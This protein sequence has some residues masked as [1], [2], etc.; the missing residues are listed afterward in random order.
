MEISYH[1][2]KSKITF[3]A[4]PNE[5]DFEFYSARKGKLC[6]QTATFEMPDNFDAGKTHPDILGLVAILV[7][8]P[9]SHREIRLA[10]K[11]S[12]QLAQASEKFFR[13][14]LE[15]VDFNLSKRQAS[16]K[17]RPSL[18]FSG[19]VDSFAALKLMPD[20]TMPVFCH[21]IVPEGMHQGLYRADAALLACRDVS[22]SHNAISI[23]TDMEYV[24][25]P[26]GFGVDW[27]NAAGAVL[28]ADHFNFNS[29][30][31]GMVME[32]AY[33]IGHPHYSNLRSRSVYRAWSPLFEA[34]GVP[35]ALPTAGLSEVVTSKIALSMRDVWHPD[36]C[37][38][39][40]A[41][42]PC[43]KCFKCFRKKILDAKLEGSEIPKNHFEIPYS[44]KEV[45]RRLLEQP[46][47]H[48]D[49]LAYSLQ[50]LKCASNSVLHALLLKCRSITDYGRGLS[51]LD[52]HYEKSFELVPEFMRDELAE[53]IRRYAEPYSVHDV[54]LIESWETGRLLEMG[55][56]QKGQKW[57]ADIL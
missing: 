53:K 7:F 13:R 25:D 51:V 21:R 6:R 1:I 43:M 19:G 8:G 50:D 12:E 38:R 41:G 46:I 40:G 23:K 42:Q 48:E 44:S 11:I 29:V 36:S 27:T 56:Y 2:Q 35:I 47:H 52:R 22:V 16:A 24:R 55:D 20:T 45:K 28:L 33:F 18:A 37:V 26:V 4:Y 49:V 5:R 9:Y 54:Q 3:E 31:F 17:A 14:T 15:P 39:G 57:L 30:A 10:W 32:S 34:A